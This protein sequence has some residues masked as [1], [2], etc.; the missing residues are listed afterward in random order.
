MWFNGF[1]NTNNS[2]LDEVGLGDEKI[3]NKLESLYLKIKQ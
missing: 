2:L 1:N 3:I